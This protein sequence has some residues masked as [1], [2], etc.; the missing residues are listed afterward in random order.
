MN[1]G[2]QQ[3]KVHYVFEKGDREHEIIKVFND[4]SEKNSVLSGLR[5]HGFE[6]KQTTTLLQPADLIAGI[7]QRCVLRQ[8]NAFPS[9]DNGLSRTRLKTFE[10]YY[11]EDGA[12]AAV[13]SGH[14]ENSCWVANAKNFSFLDGVSKN[15]F[16]RHP[17]QLKKR[18]KRLPFRT[19]PKK[20]A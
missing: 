18:L 4:W 15:F 8:F 11:S 10:R 14:D 1:E 5:G 3:R 9:L 7:V 20:S 12:T 6:S 16:Q 19:K 2:T 13:V 17:Q